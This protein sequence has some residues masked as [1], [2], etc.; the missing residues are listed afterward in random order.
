M[1]KMTNREK[2]QYALK[3]IKELKTL[4]NYW[5]NVTNKQN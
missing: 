1:N 3:R 5:K 2:I 4:I